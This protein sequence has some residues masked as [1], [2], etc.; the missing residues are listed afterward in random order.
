MLPIVPIVF[1]FVIYL[2]GCFSLG[3]GTWDIFELYWSMRDLVPWQRIEPRPPTLG[4]WTLRHWT[5]EVPQYCFY[6]LQ[7]YMLGSAAKSL[8]SLLVW[9]CL[10][11]HVSF[12]VLH[13]H[14][15]L[16][17]Q[18]PTCLGLS[19]DY[20]WWRTLGR[21]VRSGVLSTSDISLVT[22]TCAVDMVSAGF[23]VRT[24]RTLS[25]HTLEK[26]LTLKDFAQT[27]LEAVP[28]PGMSARK[29]SRLT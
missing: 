7:D 25:P 23:S 3:W 22:L 21:K 17:L 14:R 15:S 18:R 8:Q 12:L 10:W 5:R 16:I 29:S 13:D 26:T 9:N 24:A 20:N 1:C 28:I 11:V 27:Q 2:F 6:G 4:A 19:E